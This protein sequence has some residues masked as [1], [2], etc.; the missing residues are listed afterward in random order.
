MKEMGSNFLKGIITLDINFGDDFSTLVCAVC[1]QV[2]EM[3]GLYDCVNSA[4]LTR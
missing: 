1:K 4:V 3:I 2:T